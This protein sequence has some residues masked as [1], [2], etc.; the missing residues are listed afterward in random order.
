MFKFR[1][2][3]LVLSGVFLLSAIFTDSS[4]ADIIQPWSNTQLS[5]G[6]YDIGQTFKADEITYDRIVVWVEEPFAS[7]PGQ[8]TMSLY[9]NS[10]T[11]MTSRVISVTSSYEGEIYLDVSGVSFTAGQNYMFQ[12]TEPGYNW[13]INTHFEGYDG[14]DAYPDGIV[15]VSTSDISGNSPAMY[16][17]NFHVVTSVPI[18]P[19]II[20]IGSGLLGIWRLRKKR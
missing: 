1:T 18:P 6:Y 10:S 20:L 12:L 14:Q 3:M 13:F 7:S 4:N 17:L 5:I 16:D 19:G 15:V 2:I 11:L 9:D 8:I